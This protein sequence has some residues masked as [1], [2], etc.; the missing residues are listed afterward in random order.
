M[1]RSTLRP[2]PRAL[3]FLFLLLV[4]VPAWSQGY[5][6][7]TSDGT[8]TDGTTSN[9]TS[10]GSS[11]TSSPGDD[12]TSLP[13]RAD[14]AGI[15]LVGSL[16]ELRSLGLSLRGQGR[17]DVVSLPRLG[18]AVTFVGNYRIEFDRAALARADVAVLFRSGATFTDG[19]A[20]LVLGGSDSF[21]QAPRRVPLPLG[22]L[23][24]AAQVQGA[25]L[26]LDV[27][28]PSGDRA[29]LVAT[30]DPTRVALFQRLR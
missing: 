17:V 28:G 12:V 21:F 20:H 6:G 4:A 9:S 26:S 22:R 18:Y 8:T 7:S 5:S 24:E 13:V 27:L 30:F 23:A 25:F 19:R 2:G 1:M 29:H 10:G 16:A 14:T 11:V 15:T 3:A